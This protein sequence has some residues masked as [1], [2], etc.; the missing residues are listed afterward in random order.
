MPDKVLRATVI[1]LGDLGRSPRMQYH[2]AAL[3][4]A[5]V[6]VDV[7]AYLESEPL[8]VIQNHP[9]I[10]LHPIPMMA[11]HHLSSFLFVLYAAVR[12]FIQTAYLFGLLFSLKKPDLILVQNPPA[13]PTLYAISVYA[14]VRSVRWIIDWHNFSWSMAA[15]RLGPH[16]PAIASLRF[17][18]RILAS[19][20]SGH[21]CVSRAMQVELVERWNLA[22]VT[23]MR[24]RPAEMFRKSTS[25]ECLK[26]L[27]RIEQ[28]TGVSLLDSH[29]PAILVSPTSW[30]SDEDIGLLLDAAICLDAVVRKEEEAY[31]GQN[32]FPKVLIV[33]T[34]KGPLLGKYKPLIKEL[35]LHKIT[36]LTLW[37]QPE[38]YARFLGSA[39]LG[40]CC[41]R[42]SSGLDLPMKIEDMFG[43]GVPVCALDYGA[44][45]RE[46]VSP[47]ENGLFFTNAE[48]LASH[49]YELFREFPR[50]TPLL[51]TL[52]ANILNS[53]TRWQQSWEASAA[54]I[55][56]HQGGPTSCQP[57]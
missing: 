3:A 42:S 32:G 8:S 37:F 7:I 26:L 34:G 6:E 1:V 2:V 40:I 49:I 28:E 27:T 47:G 17:F 44:V 33:I 30:S 39:D 31:P 50:S 54:P 15:L 53:Q 13:L 11:T 56:F 46:Q 24:D 45:I 18:E 41:H 38:D 9:S 5:S 12:T 51:D 23:V 21:L 36:I 55:L 57:D 20:A 52:R 43:A 25:E 48:A 4:E 10:H 22:S 35:T 16:H 29:R 19:F 14:W